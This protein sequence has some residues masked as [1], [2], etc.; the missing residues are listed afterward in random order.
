MATP[1]PPGDADEARVSLAVPPH[2]P[3]PP[4]AMVLVVDDNN[5]SRFLLS[6]RVRDLGHDVA[7]AEN[8]VVAL[9]MLRLRPVD[10]VL[11]DVEMPE[12]DGMAV[13]DQMKIDPI[14]REIPVVMVSGID[15]LACVIHC[16]GHGAEDYLA[17]PFDPV[18]LSARVRAC[19][20]KKRLRDEERRKTAALELALQ[21][22]QATQ[23]QLVAQEKL[24]SLGALTAGIAHEIK[25]P[26]NFVT[27]FAQLS[28]DLV[29]EL[30][31]ELARMPAPL[32]EESQ[33]LLDFLEQNVVK[34]REH[35]QRA[36]RI[37]TSMLLHARG[38][39]AEW[40]SADLN[41][42]VTQAVTLA[43]HGQRAQE[44][45]SAI[46]LQTDLDPEAGAIFGL[47]QDL[48]RVFLNIAGNACCALLDKKKSS[49]DDFTPTLKVKTRNLGDRV[50]VRIRD[51]GGGVPAAIRDKIFQPFFTTKAAGVGTGLGLSISFDIVVR[52]HQGELRLETEEGSHAEFIIILP[53]GRKAG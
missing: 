43:Y 11:L 38:G 37:I 20:D 22:L 5:T 28:V 45:T 47:P 3:A 39:K 13:L 49:G 16:I 2:A 1:H 31:A 18:L 51:N 33:E 53:R 10:L 19:L 8:G 6:R 14:L 36:D 25:N 35:G 48:S 26:L 46:T 52:I 42:L 30:R 4:P 24:A 23:T 27:N 44:P 50:E 7:T 32:T 17:K 29:V 12:M 15:D 9:E 21:Q 40:Q 41:A 34:I